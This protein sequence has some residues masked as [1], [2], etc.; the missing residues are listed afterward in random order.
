MIYMF[1]GLLGL[2]AIVAVNMGAVLAG[3][4]ACAQLLG[5]PERPFWP[6]PASRSG[7]PIP[8]PKR[9]LLVV[10]GLATAYL[11]A[12][13]LHTAGFLID[14]VASDDPRGLGSVVAPV[15]GKAAALAGARTGDKVVAVAGEPVSTWKELSSALKRHPAQTVDVGIERGAERLTLTIPTSPDGHIGVTPVDEPH[16]I[17]LAKALTAGLSA[18]FVIARAAARAKFADRTELSGPVG[19]VAESAAPARRSAGLTFAGVLDSTYGLLFALVFS[20][21]LG[22]QRGYQAHAVQ[23]P[24]GSR[25]GRRNT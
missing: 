18:P 16:S 5:L 22:L 4:W 15:V 21:G 23:G 2:A 9:I 10:A 19:I 7:P 1:I 14:G 25:D 8:A 11:L 20:I 24:P 12:A 6:F 3:R 13:S 17:G